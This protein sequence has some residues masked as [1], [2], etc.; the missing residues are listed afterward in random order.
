[1]SRHAAHIKKTQQT[2]TRTHTHVLHT[3]R[4]HSSNTHTH[5]LHTLRRHSRHTHTLHTLRRHSRHTHTL[6][7]RRN[8]LNK[9]YRERVSPF[10][11]S[12]YLI[13][14]LSLPL[15]LSLCVF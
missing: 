14:A 5:T 7:Q 10:S 4:R 6:H 12:F 2:H 15:F 8:A 3:L 13:L 9:M 11:L 1:M